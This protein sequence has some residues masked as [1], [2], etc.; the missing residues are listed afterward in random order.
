MLRNWWTG[1]T[2]EDATDHESELESSGQLLQCY[3]TNINLLCLGNRD[4]PETP[5]PVFAARAI[6]SAIFGTPHP[7]END[8]GDTQQRPATNLTKEADTKTLRMSPTKQSQGTL[9]TPGTTAAPKKTVSFG[10]SVIDNEGKAAAGRSGLP[11]DFPGKFPSPWTPRM[12]NVE[13]SQ[14]ARP[15]S[16]TKALESAREV[17]H[18]QSTSTKASTGSIRNSDAMS[19]ME[20]KPAEILAIQKP[21]STSQNTRARN[22]VQT[23]L[24]PDQDMTT[25]LNEPHSESGKYWKMEYER[26]HEDAKVEMKKLVK[27]KQLAKSYARKKDEEALDLVEKLHRE[28]RKV[29]SMEE[30]LTE[31]AT[32]VAQRRLHGDE[33]DA[34]ELLKELA[35]RTALTLKYQD[36]VDKFQAALDDYDSE[37]DLDDEDMQKPD[38]PRKPHAVPDVSKKSR[39]ASEHKAETTLVRSEI[40]K[41]RSDLSSAEKEVCRNRNGYVKMSEDLAKARGDLAES[42]RRRRDA[43]ERCRD[44][45]KMLHALQEDYEDLKYLAKKQRHEAELLL[46]RRHD[47]NA[48]LKKEVHFLREKLSARH[49]AAAESLPELGKHG[50]TDGVQDNR[51]SLQ[52]ENRRHEKHASYSNSNTLQGEK[53]QLKLEKIKNGTLSQHSQQK[54]SPEKADHRLAELVLTEI[55]SN[56]QTSESLPRPYKPSA[57]SGAEGRRQ[58]GSPEASMLDLPSSPPKVAVDRAQLP[59]LESQFP[60]GSSRLGSMMSTRSKSA[61][62]PERVAA[63]QARLALRRAEKRK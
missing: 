10:S 58:A 32:Y 16:L 50:L 25:D 56:R 48:S 19:N 59:S 35:Y 5:G 37:I 61:L 9:M 31:L 27:Y 2:T 43:D 36:N 60:L 20:K 11:N 55:N 33:N 46:K 13:P 38:S 14:V 8:E 41:L 15:T 39:R 7:T 34:A 17:K 28:Q 47:R 63:A 26:Y 62:P 40:R 21:K 45:E 12:P 6:K 30:K 54:A 1:G 22:R 23:A 44:Q 18:K 53:D 49:T 24:E 4:P 29:V 42:D 52:G 51:A 57:V 3:W